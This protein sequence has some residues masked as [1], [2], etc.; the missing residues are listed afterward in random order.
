MNHDEMLIALSR[1]R[2]ELQN[3]P[4]LTDDTRVQLQALTA[5]IELALANGSAPEDAATIKDRLQEAVVDF[6]VHH[7]IIGGLLERITDGLANLGI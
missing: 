5:D 3:S 2:E 7:P 1:I 4:D 6:E